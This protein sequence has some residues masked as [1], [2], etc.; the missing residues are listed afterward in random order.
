MPVHFAADARCAHLAAPLLARVADREATVS[1]A[2]AA[3]PNVGAV[4][5]IARDPASPEAGVRPAHAI[6]GRR[7]VLSLFT[8]AAAARPRRWNPLTGW[9]PT[10]VVF[11]VVALA[12]VLG[13]RAGLVATPARFLAGL[14]WQYVMIVVALASTHYAAAALA[15]RAASGLSLPFGES[16]LLQLAASA[17]NRITP[18]GAGG[19]ALNAR[20][21]AR[22]GQTPAGALGSV[23]ALNVLGGPAD[24]AALA[25]I[26][27]AG[28]MVGL[29]GAGRELGALAS[30]LSG[31]LRPLQSI[32]LWTTVAFVLSVA[33]ALPLGRRLLRRT[34]SFGA[35]IGLLLRHPLRLATLVLSSAGTTVLLGLALPRAPP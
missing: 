29:R 11:S 34:G 17:A 30:Q 28:G 35:P 2:T 3:P 15:A 18:L 1:A 16:V 9:T 21:F 26:V 5:T 23:A 7:R 32:G 33:A 31:L 10:L 6:A 12:A 8:Q 24:L 22:R 13:A 4:H 27:T 25:A 19:A 20:Y 14:R